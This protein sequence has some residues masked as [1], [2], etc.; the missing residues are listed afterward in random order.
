M[1]AV[2]YYGFTNHNGAFTFENFFNVWKYSGVFLRSI[3]FTSISTLL[4]IIIGYPVAFTISRLSPKWQKISITAI[5]L[6]MWVNSLLITYAIM[7]LLEINGPI[8]G[9]LS[10]LN[11]EKVSLVNTRFA[12]LFGMVYNSICY[13]VLPIHSSLSK[14]DL[15][16]IQAAKDLG[17]NELKTFIKIIFPLSIPG[18]LSGFAMTFGPSMSNFIIS[19][20]LGGNTSLLIGELVEL[21]F[22]GNAYDPHSGSALALVLTLFIVLCTGL[23]NQIQKYSR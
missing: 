7:T 3:Y 5:T 4:C 21:K 10:F 16:I 17:A 9:L 22:L 14:I 11:F 8:N 18:I 6:P 23:A 20:M 13:V 1:Y 12:V 2:F 15:G 19:K